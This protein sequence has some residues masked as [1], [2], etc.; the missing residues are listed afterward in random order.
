M[1]FGPGK[2][3]DACTAVREATEADS[4]VLII[5]GGKLGE[6]FSV[7]TYNPAFLLKL[8]GVLRLIADQL[9]A[10]E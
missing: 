10:A 5:A 1:P 8:P 4:V 7:Q 9:E 3:D 6:G 2:Y